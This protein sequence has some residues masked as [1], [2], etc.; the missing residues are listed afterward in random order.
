M[1]TTSTPM[2]TIT[3][4]LCNLF[5]TVLFAP[6][7]VFSVTRALD[8][9]FERHRANAE[10]EREELQRRGTKTYE[11]LESLWDSATRLALV[12]SDD[13]QFDD[14]FRKSADDFEA[15]IRRTEPFV[16][17]KATNLFRELA[18]AL[19]R[20]SSHEAD[21]QVAS[22]QKATVEYVRSYV[23]HNSLEVSN[24]R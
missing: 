12:R 15:I 3:L 4:L 17:A 10:R 5:T 24:A 11:A 2:P 1:P 6:I 16:P 19:D 13:S 14:S 23:G 7:L 22:A 9:F 8:R 20:P 18:L 21:M